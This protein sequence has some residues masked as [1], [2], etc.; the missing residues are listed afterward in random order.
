[1]AQNTATEIL[2]E[3]TIGVQPNKRFNKAQTACLIA[4][5]ERG[6]SG[7][8]KD[9]FPMIHQ[10]ATDTGLDVAQVKVSTACIGSV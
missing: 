8:G 6:M 9:N 2:F 10:A 4:Y 3:D 1:M 7:T 5:F